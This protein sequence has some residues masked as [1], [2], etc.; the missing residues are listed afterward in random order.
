MAIAEALT[1]SVGGEAPD[2]GA[3]FQLGTGIVTGGA[4]QSVGLLAAVGL[5][6]DVHIH[7][8]IGAES[9]ALPEM[10][11]VARQVRHNDLLFS[12]GLELSL[13]EAVAYHPVVQREIE[14]SVVHLD[15]IPT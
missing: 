7:R 10:S 5:G 4:W 15:T 8:A 1:G 13:G 12:A 9:H 6:A 14:V 3:L 11:C 2:P